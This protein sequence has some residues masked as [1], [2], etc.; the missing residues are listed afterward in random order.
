[1]QIVHG[2]PHKAGGSQNASWAPKRE[3][4]HRKTWITQFYRKYTSEDF[5]QDTNSAFLVYMHEKCKHMRIFTHQFLSS[6]SISK[7]KNKKNAIIWAKLPKYGDAR[8]K[9]AIFKKKNWV[10]YKNSPSK[11]RILKTSRVKT[12][13]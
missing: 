7:K 3:T 5:R 9:K 10:E 12:K 4:K 1:M 11:T 2:P 13:I 8:C 6:P